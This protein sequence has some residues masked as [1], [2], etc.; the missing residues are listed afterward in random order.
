MLR[1]K[2]QL[3]GKIIEFLRFYGKVPQSPKCDCGG[4]LLPINKSHPDNNEGGLTNENRYASKE[5]S[6]E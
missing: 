4:D 3:C 1:Y 2:C 5:R 6:S